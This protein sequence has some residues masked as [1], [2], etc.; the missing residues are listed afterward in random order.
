M[1]EA[2][3]S[4]ARRDE[5]MVAVTGIPSGGPNAGISVMSVTP[6]QN[7]MV[8][9]TD[10]RS[11][12]QGKSRSIRDSVARAIAAALSRPL[13]ALDTRGHDN[14]MDDLVIM[15]AAFLLEG[16]RALEGS[17][18]MHVGLA[19]DPDESLP[20]ERRGMLDPAVLAD[21]GLSAAPSI[22]AG[23]AGLGARRQG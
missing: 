4:A 11:C 15:M 6:R 16:P 14:L 1:D 5:G 19:I 2:A 21:L 13:S 9:L 18:L 3:V 8:G 17:G 23:S 12:G 10:L 7:L 22:V 20:W